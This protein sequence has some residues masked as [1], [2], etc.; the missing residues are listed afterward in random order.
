MEIL[1]VIV[2]IAILVALGFGL[3]GMVKGGKQGSDKMFKSLVTRVTLSIVLFLF[4]M[5]AGYMGWIQPNTVILD[6]PSAIQKQ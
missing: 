4:V 5:F 2:I 6:A 1:I 3:V